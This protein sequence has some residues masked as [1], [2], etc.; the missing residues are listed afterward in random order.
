MSYNTRSKLSDSDSSPEKVN[1]RISR[2]NLNLFIFYDFQQSVPIE[3]RR[4]IRNMPGTPINYDK[5]TPERHSPM[6]KNY[7]DLN[8]ELDELRY[9]QRNFNKSLSP[10]DAR[11]DNNDYETSEND[12]SYPSV[13]PTPTK[14]DKFKQ[15]PRPYTPQYTKD[16]GQVWRKY[17]G[18]SFVLIILA[19]VAGLNLKKTST[20]KSEDVKVDCTQF[21]NL[22]NEFPN[23]NER[24][25]KILKSGVE[26]VRDDGEVLVL[27]MFS[28]D[29]R[30]MAN[31]VKKIVKMTQECLNNTM[32][33]IKLNENE[34][35]NE[36]IEKYKENLSER[37]IMI[38]NNVDK[39]AID[40]VHVLHSFCD[41]YNPLVKPLAIFIT[42]EVSSSPTGKEIDFIHNHLENR[43]KE[44]QSNVRDPL[45]T[46][47]LDQTFYLKP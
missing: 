44:I 46:R 12:Q 15:T 2:L 31:F 13:S 34:I 45:I 10:S 7:E 21:L 47:I 39:A 26:G 37:K 17:I 43:W 6:P 24:I 41:T 11:D 30:L 42:M 35:N 40:E 38:L 32:D 22:R 23:Q 14:H 9:N 4:S 33:P 8:K 36:M 19:I 25:F 20:E 1:F 16:D 3:S 27:S 5:Y 18:I 29:T 28:T